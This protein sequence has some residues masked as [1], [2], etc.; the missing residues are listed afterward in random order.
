MRRL[1]SRRARSVLVAANIFSNPSQPKFSASTS[2]HSGSSVSFVLTCALSVCSL[3]ARSLPVSFS[4]ISVMRFDLAGDVYVPTEKGVSSRKRETSWKGL[5]T[6]GCARTPRGSFSPG[7]RL[8][9]GAP[10]LPEGALCSL[11]QVVMETLRSTTSSDKRTPRE[12]SR[13][14]LGKPVL[15]PRRC[16]MCPGVSTCR[17]R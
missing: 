7:Q 8:S 9:F 13:S 14:P 12:R 4:V 11:L 1:S 10:G 6:F 5:S 17:R 2:V 15:P 16:R 3:G